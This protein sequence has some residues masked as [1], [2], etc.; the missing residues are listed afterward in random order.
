LLNTEEDIAEA[1]G[2]LLQSLPLE[3]SSSEIAMWVGHGTAQS[4]IN[5]Y[6]LLQKSVQKLDKNILISTLEEGP[7][8]LL[9]LL[10]KRRGAK[11]WLLPLLSIVGKHT[12]E[13]LAGVHRHS[14]R[15]ILELNN[16]N[17]CPV[18]RGLIEYSAFTDIWIRHLQQA[19]GAYA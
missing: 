7:E 1:A 3:R 17:C 14:W 15:S 10:G 19:T 8:P 18:S 16:Y 6:E 2:A 11:I 12:Y 4:G 9:P 13:D 5:L